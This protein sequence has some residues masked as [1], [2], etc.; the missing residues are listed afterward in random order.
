MPAVNTD[1]G[2]VSDLLDVAFEHR[3]AL[4]ANALG[5]PPPYL[6]ERGKEAG[7]T[8][9]ALVGKRTTPSD[10]SP[11]ASTSSSRRAPRPAATRRDRHDGAGARDRRRRRPTSPC[12]PRAASHPGGRWRPR[13][14][15]AP[16][17]S[18]CGSV[19]LSSEEDT[20]AASSSRSSWRRRA[21]TRSVRPLAPASRRASSAARGTTRGSEPERPSPLPMP[22][23]GLLV[24]PLGADRGGGGGR[25]AGARE[26][27][28]TTSARASG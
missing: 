10:R 4:I 12:S 19:W 7:V 26:L 17:A 22:L 5:P 13:W 24:E 16:Q 18:G 6:V 27:R 1:P 23:L 9:A 28:G 8:V 3:I 21:P 15:S 11:P 25:A 2:I 14:R 20:R